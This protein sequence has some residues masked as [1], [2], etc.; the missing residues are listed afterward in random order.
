VLPDATLRGMRMFRSHGGTVPAVSGRKLLSEVSSPG[1]FAPC[2]E[3]CAGRGADTPANACFRVGTVA[4]GSAPA[5]G[6][7][8]APRYGS[9]LLPL[10]LRSLC[11]WVR[12][13]V[14]PPNRGGF[15]DFARSARS[16]P[17]RFP[18][19]SGHCF[20]RTFWRG[21]PAGRRGCVLVCAV[22][23]VTLWVTAS[24]GGS[25]LP[26]HLTRLAAGF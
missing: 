14:T 8:L 19:A 6:R 23:A 1:S 20:D 12:R 5:A 15:T 22:A 25:K 26:A 17:P 4:A 3:R 11:S 7:P 16:P 21:C 2:R 9:D 24:M 18:C 13:F 10:R